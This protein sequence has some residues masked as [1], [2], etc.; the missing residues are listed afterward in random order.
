MS[1]KIFG[2]VLRVFIV[3]GTV[4]WLNNNPGTLTLNWLGYVV[5]TSVSFIFFLLIALFLIIALLT[6]GWQG[7][8]WVFKQALNVGSYLKKDPNKILA[9][10][11][12][13]IE[14]GN[15]KE[16]QTL[17]KEAMNL[18]PESALPAIALLKAAHLL[19]NKKMQSLALTHLKKFE[20]FAPMAF[21]DEV[22]DALRNNRTDLA[23]KIISQ[24]SKN[25][26]DEGWFLKQSLKVSIALKEWREA[27]TLLK[28]S[29]KK[30]S[31]IEKDTHQIYAFLWH[32]ISLGKGLSDS[33]RL[34]YMEKSYDH[35]PNFLEN[36][37]TLC[38]LLVQKKDKRAAQNLLEK[39]W[40]DN[41]SWSI[42]EAYC[43]ILSKNPQPLSKAR[44]A[45][46]LYDLRPDHPVSQLILIKYFIKA[47]LWGE[48]KRVLS[49]LPKD[50]PEAHVLK[51][52]L[53]KKE[54]GNMQ[55]VLKHL[56]KAMTQISYPYKC[57]KCRKSMEKWH[58]SCTHCESFL[59]VYLK[60]PITY[61]HCLDALE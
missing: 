48:A 18:N 30:G 39:A 58:I 36:L 40:H 56:K 7:L 26:S 51:A 42:S 60:H 23:K 28:K 17:A 57:T 50:V 33:E 21:Y 14:F 19:Q 9:Q 38:Q 53:S 44:K 12:S 8:L 49:L 31:F 37:L 25:Y 16:A 5:E 20:E 10:S 59:S 55:D 35:D 47:K 22:E 6:S 32:K 4:L 27:L 3:F 13:A 61:A 45:R 46:K 24:A 43:E 11:F 1:F 15:L 41:P 54:K 2:W 29:E 34:D 52:A